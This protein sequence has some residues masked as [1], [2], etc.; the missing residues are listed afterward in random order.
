MA[1]A[2]FVKAFG[3]TFLG[4]A[5]GAEAAAA[6][7]VDTGMWLVMLILAALCIAIGALP[8]AALALIEPAVRILTDSPAFAPVAQA[9][10]FLDPVPERGASYSGLIVLGAIGILGLL[11]VVGVRR[12]AS[13][14]EP[15]RVPAWDCGFPDPRAQTQYTSSSF[16]QPIRRVFAGP[17]FGARERVDMP[18]PGDMRPARFTLRLIDPIWDWLYRPVVAGLEFATEKMNFLQFM[19]IRAYLTAMFAALVALLTIVAVMQ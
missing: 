5:R 14:V 11:L 9:W 6:R 7:E 2:C 8:F 18:E 15:L 16:A 3:V 10:L 13:Q 4:R 1:A 12:L 17:V 19:T